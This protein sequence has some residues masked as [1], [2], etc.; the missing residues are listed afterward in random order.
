[1]QKNEIPLGKAEDLRGKIFGRLTPL[2]RVAGDITTWRCKCS[3]G[4]EVNV[5]AKLLKNGHTT[6]CGCFQKEQ[7]SQRS[8]KDLTNKRF[9]HLLVLYRTNDYISP[10][11]K[12]RKVVYRCLCDCG[13]K[14]DINGTSLVQGLTTSCGCLKSKGEEK[15][16]L[17]LQKHKLNFNSQKTFESCRFKSSDSLARFDFY[18]ENK[19]LIEYDG[20]QHFKSGGWYTEDKFKKIQERDQFKNQWC[21]ENN[22]PLIRI[23]YTHLDDIC[24]NDLKL[25]TS[26]FIYQGEESEDDN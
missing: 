13:A 12:T 14:V 8:F 2:Y 22:I 4:N 18:V 23:P 6:S 1:M 9:G 26:Q 15:I 20:Q 24:I 7:I 25:E 5:L 3:C 10:S 21:K 19:Y 17:L 16:S 11:N